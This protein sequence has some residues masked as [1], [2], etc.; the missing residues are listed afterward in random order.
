MA[1]GTPI[2]AAGPGS[3]TPAHCRVLGARPGHGTVG[4]RPTGLQ[5]HP[6]LPAA[7]LREGVCPVT[8]SPAPMGLALQ[9]L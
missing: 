2:E 1:A 9:P 8:A 4:G 6:L 7:S 3:H 5:G